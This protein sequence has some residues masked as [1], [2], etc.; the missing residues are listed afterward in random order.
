[1]KKAIFL[2]I[3]F[4]AL[5]MATA[6]AQAQA[7][8]YASGLKVQKMDEAN[9][10]AVYAFTYTLNADATA[11]SIN[12]NGSNGKQISDP[13]LLTKGTHTAIL[14]L[15]DLPDG[16]Y[17]W[18]VTATATANTA[19]DPVKV[20]NDAEYL[21]FHALRGL[22]VDNG[23]ESPF[24]GRVYA[25]EG[26][27]TAAATNIRT[28][29]DG[30]YIYNAALED[31]TEQGNAA[32]SSGVVWG[33][34][35]TA[36]SAASPFRV[37]VAPDGL[38]FISDWSD[39]HAGV[40]TMDP[41]NPSAD[42]KPVFGGTLNS[43]GVAIADGVEIHG[44]ISHCYV[45][46]TGDDTKLYTF[47]EDLGLASGVS[48][49]IYRYDI[50]NLETTWD[51]APSALIYDDAANGNV[52]QNGNSVIS[53]DGRGGWWIYQY[54]AN[55]N[56][57]AI[58]SLIHFNGTSIDF[59]SAVDAVDPESTTTS[60]II[61]DSYQGGMALNDGKSMM[62]LTCNGVVRV[63]DITFDEN[64][65]PIIAL[66]Y[67][68]TTSFGTTSFSVALDRADNIYVG[69]NASPFAVYALPKA[70][71]TF[72]TPAPTAQ[73]ITIDL[74]SGIT[75]VNNLGDNV[76]LIHEKGNIHLQADGLTIVN[77]TVYDIGGVAVR[78]NMVG[79]SSVDVPTSGLAA[80]VYLIHL[81]T[82]KG[83]VVRRFINK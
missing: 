33:L 56:N 68:V 61:G 37:T 9:S 43:S 21:G 59:I 6:N 16:D 63:F 52:Q 51:V 36:N 44:S 74:T 70:D 12:F 32:Y 71:N 82:D 48:G 78:S 81:N 50:G 57:P 1:M 62:A 42:F 65:K 23:F 15:S 47:D 29:T 27:E 4:A 34:S 26:N 67:K 7:N 30:V 20:S 73:K 25:T 18:S 45:E 80:G 76:L 24:F 40:W 8:I 28:T 58:P 41:A 66:K 53:P 31:V 3:Y 2:L 38:V 13:D 22:A 60:S 39:T 72:T 55:D 5:S 83:T 77:Y 11:V 49:N 54:R 75:P 14:S 19:T 64:G 10:V 35:G 17:L 79:K 69:G 46:G